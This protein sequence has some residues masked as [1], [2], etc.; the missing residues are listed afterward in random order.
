MTRLKVTAAADLIA[1]MSTARAAALPV[2]ASVMARIPAEGA[3]LL[4]LPKDG[5]AL[6]A[7]DPDNP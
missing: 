3:K 4:S 5:P 1:D 7:L 2:G 6:P